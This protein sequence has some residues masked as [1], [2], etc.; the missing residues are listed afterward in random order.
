MSKLLAPARRRITGTN[1]FSIQSVKYQIYV[2]F[3]DATQTEGYVFVEDN[4]GHQLAVVPVGS[5]YEMEF[6]CCA[7]ICEKIRIIFPKNDT[8]I[9]EVILTEW[10]QTE[11]CQ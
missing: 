3:L 7:L 1:E 11:C 9:K 5:R 2:P 6:T 8:P 10:K 4:Q